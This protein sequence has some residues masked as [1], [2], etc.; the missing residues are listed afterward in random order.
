MKKWENIILHTIG[1]GTISSLALAANE[2]AEPIIISYP[3]EI[4]YAIL[5]LAMVI[6]AVGLV[7]PKIGISSQNRW[8]I[9]VA[10]IIAG[11]LIAPMIY[12]DRVVI[13]PTE[14]Y[15]NTGFWFLPTKKGFKYSEVKLVR[16][17]IKEVGLK[18]RATLIWEIHYLN[19]QT[20]DINPGDLWEDNSSSIISHLQGY[21]VVFAE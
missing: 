17:L 13:T 16:P 3:V 4:T 18:R 10:G 19:G 6:L 5:A 7:A 20:K 2:A 9:I 12:L 15:Q 11:L 1:F 8:K 14:V 21:R